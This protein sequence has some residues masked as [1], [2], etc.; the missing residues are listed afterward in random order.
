MNKK[1][2]N[3]ALVALATLVWSCGDT[4][5]DA[6]QVLG[7]LQVKGYKVATQS[8]NSEVKTTANIIASEQVELKAPIAGQVLEIYFEEGAV[9]NKGQQ[10]IRM[11]DRS[12][13]AQ[14]VGVQAALENAQKD[15]ERKKQLLVVEGSSQEEIDNAFSTVETLKSQVEQLKVNIDLANVKAPF[16]GKL[17]MRDFSKGAFLTQGQIITS[18]T[19]IDKLKVDFTLAQNHQKSIEI[20]KKIAVLIENDTLEAEIYA[21]SPVV[22]ADSRTINVRAMLKQKEGKMYMPGVF[23]EII[24]TTNFIN[25]ALLIPTQAVVP[26]I[27]DQT[28]YVVKDGKAQKKIVQIGNRTK[29]LVHI[30]EGLSEGEVVLTTGLLH[31]KD[32]MPVTVELIK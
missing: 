9:V 6:Q 30:T 27:T 29:D 19:E 25:D 10:L 21:I 11:D 26:S 32:G 13:K 2:K 23:A 3:I 28:I 20:G 14:L 4:K 16:S 18:L 7:S 17:G 5:K 31:V 24:I 8:F 12:W 1:I 15:Y 22:S